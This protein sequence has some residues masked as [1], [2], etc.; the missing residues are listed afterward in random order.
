MLTVRCPGGF[1]LDDGIVSQIAQAMPNL[2]SLIIESTWHRLDVPRVT[3]AGLRDLAHHCPRLAVLGLSLNALVVPP[4]DVAFARLR[5]LFL[6]IGHAPIS[7]PSAVADFLLGIFR[8]VT[9]LSKGGGG[10]NQDAIT[11]HKHWREVSQ[12][13]ARSRAAHAS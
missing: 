8:E 3:L 10:Q 13:V 6:M 2:R 11:Y 7:D 4:P 9:V 5:R 12:L 1:D